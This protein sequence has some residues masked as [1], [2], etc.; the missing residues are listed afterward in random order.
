MKRLPGFLLLVLTSL[1]YSQA[2][3]FLYYQNLVYLQNGSVCKDQP[4]DAGFLVYLNQDPDHILTHDAPRW[5]PQTDPNIDGRGAFGVE[6]GNYF[7]Q[8]QVGDS[9]TLIFTSSRAGQQGVLRER[10]SAFPWYRFPQILNLQALEIPAPPTAIRL[11]ATETG[12]NRLEWS[13]EPGLICHIYRRSLSDTLA[14]GRQRMQ[15]ARVAR[16]IT[17]NSFIDSGLPEDERFGY[18][19]VTENAQ[20]RLSQP[21]PDVF[22]Y[23]QAIKLAATPGSRNVT[24]HWSSITTEKIDGYNIYR[25]KSGDKPATPLAYCGP[26]TTYTD[27]RLQ[28]GTKW[29]Y[30]VTGRISATGELGASNEF[31]ITTTGPNDDY[32]YANLKT[33]IVIYKNTKQGR[34]QPAQVADIRDMVEKARLFYWINSGM[35][36]NMEI[37]WYEIED[38]KSYTD[39]DG[40]YFQETANDLQELGVVNTQYDVIFRITPALEGYWSLGVP[41][42][43]FPGPVRATGFSHSHWPINTGVRYPFRHDSANMGLTWIFVHEVQHALDALYDRNGYPEFYHGDKPWE[44]PAPCGEHFSFQAQM[45]RHFQAYEELLTEWGDIYETADADRDRFPDADTRVPLDE[46]RFHSNSNLADSDTDALTDRQE[47]LNGIYSGS[48]PNAPDTDQDGRPDGTDAYPRYPVQTEIPVFTPVIDG[49]I[50]SGWTQMTD[51]VSF[52]TTAY[53]PALYLAYDAENLYLALKLPLLSTPEILID[54]DADGWWWSSGNTDIVINPVSGAFKS[55]ASWDAA[56]EVTTYALSQKGPGGMWDTAAAYR[57]H[58]KRRVIDP[59]QV[60]LKINYGVPVS[61]IELALPKSPYAG[62]NLNAGDKLALNLVYHSIGANSSQWATAFDLYEFVEF[63]LGSSL[64]VS[65]EN[66]TNQP[67]QVRLNQNY[68]NP[69]NPR[70][71]IEFYLPQ[72]TFTDLAIYNVAGQFIKQLLHEPT[73]AGMYHVTWDGTDQRG[74]P[75]ANGIYMYRLKTDQNQMVKKMSYIK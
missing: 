54:F 59:A 11:S 53:A 63:T 38:Y 23:F 4:P 33:A 12:D 19:I 6:L 30:Q 27:T 32:T 42:L 67:N 61:E 46:A 44:F 13:A 1:A 37:F 60:R 57:T 29:H 49:T 20:G 64:A 5:K 51:T 45:F 14:N 34:I 69:F 9:V 58:F 47:A 71:H 48:N 28:P 68:P 40:L 3:D 21:S 72:R 65:P 18:V 73:P 25:W 66:E 39:P 55:L 43:N 35:K 15:Y 70:T 7:P 41:V 17:E 31:K 16:G 36:L 8:P 75:V 24:L 74:E 2:N 22:R 26:E 56:N 62:L 52:A 10:I 50:E